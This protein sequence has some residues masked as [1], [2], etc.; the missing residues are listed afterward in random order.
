M[1]LLGQLTQRVPITGDVKLTMWS[2]QGDVIT[3][4]TIIGTENLLDA[5]GL[6]LWNWLEIKRIF[7]A[8]DG[9]L[10]IDF[11]ANSP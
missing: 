4:E 7:A 6:G 9:F 2:K 5:P 3:D 10:H 1:V 8:P 11:E